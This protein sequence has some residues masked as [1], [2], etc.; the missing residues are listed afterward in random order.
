MLSL[1]SFSS[2]ARCERRLLRACGPRNDGSGFAPRD[3]KNRT[4]SPCPLPLRG[5][6][7][8]KVDLADEAFD[9]NQALCYR[10]YSEEETF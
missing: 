2:K 1:P 7:G 9:W 4:P 3:D 5:G 6:E 8:N 10:I